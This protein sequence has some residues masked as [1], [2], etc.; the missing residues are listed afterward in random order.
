MLALSHQP[1]PS[2]CSE[3]RAQRLC[4]LSRT[5][6]VLPSDFSTTSSWFC[7]VTGSNICCVGSV[8]ICFIYHD[9]WCISCTL[10]LF[11]FG[12]HR[13]RTHNITHQWLTDSIVSQTYW[14]PKASASDMLRVA[15]LG[16]VGWGIWIRWVPHE[17]EKRR[18]TKF[19]QCFLCDIECRKCWYE[20]C[21]LYVSLP[22]YLYRR[23]HFL[24]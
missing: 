9:V 8:D 4:W 3:S 2:R 21:L 11:T 22:D 24:Y 15:H 19:I 6:F 5:W 12:L 20:L 7:I 14:R 23:T 10:N 18:L 17:H 13:Q 1:Q 16:V